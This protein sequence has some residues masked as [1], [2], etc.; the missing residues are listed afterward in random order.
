MFFDP[1]MKVGV[2][3][4][5]AK[6]VN[7]DR[8]VKDILNSINTIEI[9]IEDTFQLEEISFSEIIDLYDIFQD[10]SVKVNSIALNE[11]ICKLKAEDFNK[12]IVV[13]ENLGAKFIS[14]SYEAFSYFLE[15]YPLSSVITEVCGSG[16]KVCILVTGE[17]NVAKARKLVTGRLRG[18]TALCIDI[19][20]L[21]SDFLNVLL[22]NVGLIKI[23][24]VCNFS[25]ESP[26]IRLPVFHIK[27][28]VNFYETLSIL[29]GL[30]YSEYLILRYEK[31]FYNTYVHDVGKIL[32]FLTDLKSFY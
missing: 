19:A 5:Y 18:F 4:S 3:I 26:H 28:K 2:S 25:E 13:A 23:I 8:K 16:V 6:L 30:L 9:Y 7:S 20:L 1:Y 31:M 29:N 24:Y 27:G 14:L 21:K 17:K 32:E 11:K 12:I 10:R 15:R 22:N